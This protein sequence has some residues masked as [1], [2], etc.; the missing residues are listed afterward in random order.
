MSKCLAISIMCFALTL[1]L[2]ACG[3]GDGG[4]ATATAGKSGVDLP[5]VIPSGL[6]L[7]DDADADVTTRDLSSSKQV[8]ISFTTAEDADAVYGNLKKYAKDNGFVMAVDNA[9]HHRFASKSN[10]GTS[11]TV[12]VSDMRSVTV[13]TV[14]FVIPA[15]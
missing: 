5:D 11:L 6:P 14:T 2:V 9:D 7:P 4:S 10:S 8:I 1:P 15:N 12:S 3:S 13:T